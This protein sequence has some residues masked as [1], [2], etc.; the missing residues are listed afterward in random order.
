MSVGWVLG[1]LWALTAIAIVAWPV[2]AGGRR[3]GGGGR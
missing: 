1:G 2:L 3:R